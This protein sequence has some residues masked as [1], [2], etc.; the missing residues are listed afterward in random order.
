MVTT[1]TGAIGGANGYSDPGLGYGLGDQSRHVR[2]LGN[3]GYG[4][5]TTITNQALVSRDLRARRSARSG[6][7]QGTVLND[8][9]S[10]QILGTSAGTT[11]TEPLTLSRQRPGGQPV[12]SRT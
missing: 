7:G 5:L 8:G 9:S 2:P 11:F 12:R 4:G 10:I 3:N 1:L 6:H